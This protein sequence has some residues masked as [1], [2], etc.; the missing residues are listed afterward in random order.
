MGEMPIPDD[1]EE[2]TN[3][4]CVIELEVPNSPKWLGHVVGQVADLK[5]P[6]VWDDRTGDF[7]PIVPIVERILASYDRECFPP[8]GWSDPVLLDTIVEDFTRVNFLTTNPY[9]PLADD[10]L[11]LGVSAKVGSGSIDITTV[12]DTF[13]TGSAWDI[14]QLDYAPA[15]GIMCALAYK[16]FTTA[17]PIGTV[18][19]NLSKLSRQICIASMGIQGSQEV[20]FIDQQDTEFNDLSVLQA[21]LPLPPNPTDYTIGA[22]SDWDD[23]GLVKGAAFTEVVQL[24]ST[25]GGESLTLQVQYNHVSPQQS[26]EWSGLTPITNVAVFNS[27]LGA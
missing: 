4:Y 6:I 11:V 25:F 14:R 2:S 3:G 19:V 17:P 9:Q 1:W 10:L 13:G 16:R 27:L 15:H 18:T 26:C 21:D 12:T 8:S 20:G 5:S 7:K 23:T 24:V 22:I